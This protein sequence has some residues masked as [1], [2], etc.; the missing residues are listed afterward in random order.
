M[1]ILK[2]TKKTG[3]HPLFR[4]YCFRKTRGE[5]QIDQGIKTGYKNFKNLFEAI[6][7]SSEKITKN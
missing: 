1:T 4:R 3:F 7:E 2:V 6:K 5:S